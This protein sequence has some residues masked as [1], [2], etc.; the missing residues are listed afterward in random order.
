[1]RNDGP[2][3]DPDIGR[4]WRQRGRLAPPR[5]RVPLCH[6][7]QVLRSLNLARAGRLSLL[8]APAGY[9]KTTVLSQWIGML[10]DQGVG[11]AW[12]SLSARE[13]DPGAFLNMLAR[14][15]H[16]SGIDMG[17]TGLLLDGDV[18]PDAALDAI[19]GKLEL[20][21]GG[22]VIILDDFDNVQ[23]A[24][25]PRLID[26][27]TE[28]LPS[29]TH[30]VLAARRKPPLAL[31][32]LR[33]QGQVRIIEPEELR[34]E[35]EEITELLR[36][37]IPE[38]QLRDIA[39]WTQ[40]WPVAV[41]ML[42][43]W[44]EREGTDR[45][46][47]PGRWPAQPIT[48]Y[49]AEQ[50]F[51]GLDPD[52]RDFL[53]IVATLDEID[54]VALDRIMGMGDS[55]SRLRA[56]QTA[57]PSLIETAETGDHPLFRLHPLVA[58][59]ARASFPLAPARAA[60]L[61]VGLAR[62]FMAHE[63]PVEAIRHAAAAGDMDAVQA[64]I[65]GLR[66]L[67]IFLRTGL[68]EVRAIIREIPARLLDEPRVAL[69]R[70]LVHF[71]SGFFREGSDALA[72]I[73]EPAGGPAAVR[74]AY[75][76]ERLALETTFR[77][78]I[79]DCGA[80][81]DKALE[82]LRELTPNDPLMWAWRVN[83]SI[84]LHEQRGEI[85][86]ARAAVDQCDAIY[87]L[88]GMRFA[89]FHLLIHR[90]LLN[91]AEGNLR[92]ASGEVTRTLKRR[93]AEFGSDN[94]VLSMARLA[95]AAIAYERRPAE[96]LEEMVLQALV[97]FGDSESWFEQRAVAAPILA[98]IAYY[99]GGLP[100]VSAWVA[101]WREW[102]AKRGVTYLDVLLPALEARYAL[103]A[104]Q[105][106]MADG[107]LTPFLDRDIALLCPRWRERETMLAALC[108]RALALDATGE[109]R[110]HA[111]RMHAEARGHG[112][113]RGIIT[114][115]ILLSHIA[116]A[117]GD[118]MAAEA[119]MLNAIRAAHPDGYVMPFTE[120]GFTTRHILE[121]LLS[122][123]ALMPMDSQHVEL[124]IRSF[125][126]QPSHNPHD[127]SLR[128]IEIMRHLSDGIS[129]KL[130]ARRMGITENTVKFH[131]KKAFQKLGVTSRRAAAAAFTAEREAGCYP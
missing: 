61:H 80:V 72:H 3:P 107:L 69:M 111:Q 64:V 77:I 59:A 122:D 90:T 105:T 102:A 127:L 22:Q 109:A 50:V 49:L 93:R 78:Y 119:E 38:D 73:T 51:A 29:Q 79:G 14:A 36:D 83:L 23:G 47:P 89:S 114:A 88:Q 33:T 120:A 7:H 71:K 24:D 19:A 130:I 4:T 52:Q 101:E 1:M 110:T 97:Q 117:D 65:D 30:L 32:R 95:E 37:S 108:L 58:E 5:Q 99:R 20:S 35:F 98:D 18:N 81:V 41:Q 27:I 17:D 6:R 70:A 28:L 12:C 96:A 67:D 10:H 42:R 54:P 85:R 74:A 57:L 55:L 13:S 100:A 66:P 112:R 116:E 62:W 91:L 39:D 34:L 106:A 44:R 84:V 128:E 87:D 129:N 46:D 103:L 9:G 56:L 21:D 124:A 40:G 82:R 76:V 48:D 31:S 68:G 118:G 15:L 92:E 53:G 104:G 113:L 16:L 8:I 26:E 2:L 94:P 43:L 115:H 25:V 86:Q 60:R 131:L 123:P 75:Q 125:T 11:A 126:L 121:R 63:R 45:V